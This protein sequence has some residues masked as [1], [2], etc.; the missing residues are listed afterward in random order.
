MLLTV[1]NDSPSSTPW[2][3]EFICATLTKS[4]RWKWLTVSLKI[5]ADAHIPDLKKAFADLGDVVSL[6]GPEIDA[7]SLSDAD[8]LLVRA[9]TRVDANLLEG[10]GV[11]FVGSATS[12]TDHIDLKYLEKSG[13]GFSA[14]PGSNAESVCQ[15]VLAALLEVA[16]RKGSRLAGRSLGV[17]GGGQIGSR[18]ARWATLLGMQVVICDPPLQRQTG[19]SGLF[20]PLEEII[21]CDF[22]TLHVPLTKD[23]RDATYH[24]FDVPILTALNRAQVLINSSRGAVINNQALYLGLAAGTLPTVV[25]D[26]W[27]GEPDIDWR[28]LPLVEIGSAHIAGYSLDGKLDATWKIR[29]EVSRFFD[30]APSPPEPPLARSLELFSASHAK[31]LQSLVTEL[32]PQVYRIREDDRLLRAVSSQEP[33]A[34]AASFRNLRT[35][36]RVRRDFAGCRVNLATGLKEYAEPLRGLGFSTNVCLPTDC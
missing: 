21:H 23:G 3:V 6:P 17:V 22:I 28:L 26:V 14:A 19:D 15:Y 33:S 1:K 24:L 18:V 8:L 34:R 31:D 5:V 7:A 10:S 9:E 11:A 25:L 27:E 32:V 20:R 4:A 16:Q 2:K 30:L 29:R 12:G 36:Y 13:I 35:K